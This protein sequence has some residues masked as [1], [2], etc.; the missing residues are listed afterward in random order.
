MSP[1]FWGETLEFRDYYRDYH[2]QRQRRRIWR[3]RKFTRRLLNVMRSKSLLPE[4]KPFVDAHLRYTWRLWI[5]L[6]YFKFYGGRRLKFF[7]FHRFN[8][9][10][11]HDRFQKALE[12]Y[13][14][15]KT[16]KIIRKEFR[17]ATR[18]ELK[19]AS[20]Q[21]L[22]EWRSRFKIR[23]NEKYRISRKFK[24]FDPMFVKKFVYT[25]KRI[26]FTNAKFKHLLDKNYYN[27]ASTRDI[28]ID[29]TWTLIKGEPYTDKGKKT[30]K[31]A[32]AYLKAAEKA[33]FYLQKQKERETKIQDSKK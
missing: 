24:Q 19:L 9:N 17:Y 11:D 1:M 27:T 30:A 25:H 29:F 10:Y 21:E 4:A 20:N 31:L 23:M 18:N 15:K 12:S 2:S 8:Y 33:R 7:S 6:K 32:N 22:I 13:K 26:P 5:K 3:K 28:I 16:I 14:P